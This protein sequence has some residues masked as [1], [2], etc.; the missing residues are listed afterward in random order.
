MICIVDVDVNMVTTL[1]L[2]DDL[3][4]HT[5]SLDIPEDA[6]KGALKRVKLSCA[7]TWAKRGGGRIFER[8]ILAGHYGCTFVDPT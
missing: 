7:G 3:N 4:L 1:D 8:G 6:H 2:R 5:C